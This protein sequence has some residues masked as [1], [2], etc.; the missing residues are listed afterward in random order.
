M[1]KLILLLI[2]FIQPVFSQDLSIEEKC[3]NRSTWVYAIG[4][5][6]IQQV[7]AEDVVERLSEDEQRPF[8]PIEIAQLQDLVTIIYSDEIQ[9]T[10]ASDVAAM[11]FEYRQL[12]IDTLSKM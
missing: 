11:S 9:L 6:R 2:L 12:C 3:S 7:P 5:K 1:R 8:H 10:T 4:I